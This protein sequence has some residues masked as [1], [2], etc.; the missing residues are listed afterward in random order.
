[1]RS[2]NAEAGGLGLPDL[3][4]GPRPEGDEG[5]KPGSYAG[6]LNSWFPLLLRMGLLSGGGGAEKLSCVRSLARRGLGGAVKLSWLALA[7]LLLLPSPP[8][9]GPL[10]ASTPTLGTDLQLNWGELG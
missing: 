4:L 1:M 8:C 10:S 7:G 6:L 9:C 5:S 2:W 3:L